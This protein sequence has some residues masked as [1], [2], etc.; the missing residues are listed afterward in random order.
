ME[1]LLEL[2]DRHTV[3]HLFRSSHRKFYE[4]S[5]YTYILDDDKRCIDFG[6]DSRSALPVKEIKNFSDERVSELSQIAF[7]NFQT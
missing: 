6:I 5:L 3:R 4:T 7:L 1:K 2:L